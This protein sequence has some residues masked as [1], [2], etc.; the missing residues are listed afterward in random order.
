MDLLE[1]QAK[2]LFREVG[3]PVLPSQ[4]I[5]A[6]RD[7]KNLKI[8]Y[9]VVLKSQVRRGKR[10]K[11]GGI[12]FAAN[13]IDAIAVAQTIFNL[14]IQGEYPNLLLAEVKYDAAQEFYLAVTLDRSVRRPV[15][16]GSQQGGAQVESTL[17]QVQHV[18]V[19]QEFS[20][21][22]ARR[23]AVKMGLEGILIETI[24]EIVEKMYRLFSQKDLD[25][26]EIN[27]LGIN[28]EKEVMA[29]DGKVVV[30]DNALLR[31]VDLAQMATKIA[32]QPLQQPRTRSQT[33]RSISD[34]EDALWVDLNG[35]IAIICNGA[36]L[37]MATLDLVE[38]AGGKPASFLN[39]GGETHYYYPPTVKMLSAATPTTA[40]TFAYRRLEQ[41]LES[42]TQNP[43]VKVIVVNIFGSFMSCDQVATVIKAYLQKHQTLS[44]DLPKIVVRLVGHD[45]EPAKAQLLDTP[46]TLVEHLD[47]AVAQAIALAKL[48]TAPS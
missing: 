44:G 22:Y 6:P 30:N 45:V 13:T 39:L 32:H 46:V 43:S 17:K 26:L 19:D 5:S 41:G 1:Y 21:F 37:T 18:V 29:L 3:I 35:E 12:R 20:P 16:L 47:Q 2:E 34:E 36:G 23:L 48:S 9:P 15:L 28:L 11:A 24:S 25:L 8:P 4:H 7:L 10:G 31:H 14:P 38:Q 27:P 40:E 33:D 42:I